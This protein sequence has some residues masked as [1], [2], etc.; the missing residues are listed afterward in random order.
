MV[1]ICMLKSAKKAARSRVFYSLKSSSTT[2]N[3]KRWLAF[4]MMVL[5]FSALHTHLYLH[6][7]ISTGFAKLR[8]N[9]NR[10]KE[11][12]YFELFWVLTGCLTLKRCE[13]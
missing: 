12:L 3:V 13:G 6:V 9:Q 4:V 7:L 5:E 10:F 2:L 8:V 1:N 11:I